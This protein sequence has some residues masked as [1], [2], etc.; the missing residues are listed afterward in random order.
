MII[1]ELCKQYNVDTTQF[2][3]GILGI[4]LGDKIVEDYNK[5]T[6]TDGKI[7]FKGV[8]GNNKSEN[9]LTINLTKKI[10]EPVQQ[11]EET[12][13]IDLTKKNI[14]ELYSTPIVTHNISDGVWEHETTYNAF[15]GE[16]TRR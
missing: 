13:Q 14:I 15:G 12:N 2:T 7:T 6:N 5:V 16:L 1:E 3:K 11:Y 8:T 10:I 9:T 4:E